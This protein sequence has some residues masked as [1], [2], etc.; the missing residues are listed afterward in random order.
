MITTP[1]SHKGDRM[2]KRGNALSSLYSRT[3]YLLHFSPFENAEKKVSYMAQ[4]PRGR[5]FIR[6]VMA[7]ANALKEKNLVMDITSFAQMRTTIRRIVNKHGTATAKEVRFLAAQISNG[8]RVATVN[9]ISH[10]ELG[11]NIVRDGRNVTITDKIGTIKFVDDYYNTGIRHCLW[12]LLQEGSIEIGL[13]DQ[14]ERRSL[15]LKFKNSTDEFLE[16]KMADGSYFKEKIFSLY[17]GKDMLNC[18]RVII[19]K[20][21]EVKVSVK[22]VRGSRPIALEALEEPNDIVECILTG[23]YNTARAHKG[24]GNIDRRDYK[25]AKMMLLRKP[26]KDNSLQT[27]VK[28]VGDLYGELKPVLEWDIA[29]YRAF[30]MR[31]AQD[32]LQWEGGRRSAYMASVQALGELDVDAG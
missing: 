5:H 12:N 9:N 1:A 10:A 24:I 11:L 18:R 29:T 14:R 20:S 15:D 8:Y 21:T 3:G 27:Y 17:G 28:W 4:L 7:R 26:R 22:V 19:S 13:I 6:R 32:L 16:S 25:F 30:V 2:P 23:G 31:A